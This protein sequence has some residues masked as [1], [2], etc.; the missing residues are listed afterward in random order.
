[1]RIRAKQNPVPT[2]QKNTPCCCLPP[3]G[4]LNAQMIEMGIDGDIARG[5]A[6]GAN[7][8]ESAL[9]TALAIATA[10]VTPADGGG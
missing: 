5:A 1:M 4:L 9:A 7:D 2:A 6:Q 3:R 10:T 8:M